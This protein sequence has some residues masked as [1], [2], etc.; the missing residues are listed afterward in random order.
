[1]SDLPTVLMLGTSVNGY[2]SNCIHLE[3]VE[4]FHPL[5]NGLNLTSDSMGPRIIDTFISEVH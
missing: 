2:S 4:T 1:V 5:T 3:K